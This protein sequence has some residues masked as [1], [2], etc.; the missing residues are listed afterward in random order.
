[1]IGIL[2]KNFRYVGNHNFPQFTFH[3]GKEYVTPLTALKCN[4][5]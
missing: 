2:V 5:K 4:T 1:V 3:V